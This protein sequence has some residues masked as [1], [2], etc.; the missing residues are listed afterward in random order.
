MIANPI[1]R[2]EVLSSLR[3]NKAIIL[4]VLFLLVL[5]A[6]VWVFWPVGGL[7]DIGGQKA[8][9][10]LAIIAI[11]ELLMV[12]MFSSAFT[13]AA[14]TTEK[15]RNTWEVLFSSSMKPWEIALGKMS[16]SLSF[17]LLLVF[18]GIPALAALFL[19][20]G[21]QGTE[22]I[23][24]I[25]VLFLTAIYLGMIGLLVSSLMHRSYRSVIVAYGIVL[26]VCFVVAVPA[27]PVS[28]SG[29]AGGLLARQ[30]P[31]VQKV[32]HVVASLSPLQA[33]LSVVIPG[34]DYTLG[35]AG[36]PDYWRL[37]IPISCLVI[38]GTGLA[39]LYKLRQPIKVHR[40][41]AKLK[42]IERG[43]VSA[44]T[45]LFI[46]D[47]RKRK[48][49]IRWWQNPMLMKEFR[50]RPMLQAQ[51]LLRAIG[52]CLIVS[53]V[54]MIMVSLSLQAFMGE[55]AQMLPTMAT[56]VAAMM[57]VLILLA[58]PAM[59]GGTISSDRETGIWDL[60]RVT[61]MP[62]WRMVSGKFQASIVPL[63]LFALATLPALLILLYINI[64][65][66]PKM[67]HICYVIGVTIL[68]VS[69][70]GTFFSSIFS[71][72]AAATACTY[73]LVMGVQLLTMLVLLGK[74]LFS[75]RFVESIL[76]L[77]PVMAA[78]DAAGHASMSEYVGLRFQHMQIMGVAIAVMFVVTV[79]RV[80]QLRRA[81]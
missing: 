54:L 29:N 79:F 50:T 11:G 65:L 59:A 66:W 19:L 9:N 18:S 23:A 43:Q 61:R 45:F 12:A 47:P 3:T 48:R 2:K 26:V 5:A 51:W 76:V 60:I 4:Q 31:G 16:G 7:Q 33:M 73:A 81:E 71:K 24:V 41:L 75:V 55:S 15:E 1:I 13:A 78:M 6:L 67:V 37:F 49:M 62:S 21:V 30:E 70:A 8:R 74:S 77:N 40:Q 68:F 32:L 25:G 42:V 56:A 69:T 22:V 17:L 46:V 52:L 35:A 58:G 28:A 38:L 64:D 63:L 44:R 39:G 14:I 10:L 53:V 57:V 36:M 80:Y 20:G 27:W 72:T 34:S